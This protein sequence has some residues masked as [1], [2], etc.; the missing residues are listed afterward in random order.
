LRQVSTKGQGKQR[1]KF[2]AETIAELRKV[3]WPTRQEATYLTTIVIV[4]TVIMAMVLW[5]IDFGFSELMSVI[6][7]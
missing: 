6:L 4:V 7:F 3:A 5:V 2:I 1:F